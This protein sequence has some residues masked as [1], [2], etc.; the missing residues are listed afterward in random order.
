MNWVRGARLDKYVEENIYKPANLRD[1]CASWRG[2]NGSL[3]GLGI[4]HNDLQHGNVIVQEDEALRLV[5]YDGIFLPQFRGAPSPELGHRNFQHPLRAPEDYDEQVDNFPS[6]VIYLSL[7][8]LSHDPDLWARFYNQEN[9][10]LGKA[11]F[12]DPANSEC[13]KA[14][15]ASP[16]DTVRSLA[17]QLEGFCSIPVGQVPDLEAV[18]GDFSA[19]AR[20]PQANAASSTQ[21]APESSSAAPTTLPTARGVGSEYRMLIQTGLASPPPIYVAPSVP[22]PAPPPGGATAVSSQQT[23]V[24]RKCHLVNPIDLIYCDDERCYAELNLGYNKPCS[25]CSEPVPVRGSYCPECGA[26]LA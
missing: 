11:D 5:D 8:A 22:P 2:A 6:L 25:N 19:V 21:N 23:V 3:R 15:K 20:P 17:E 14:L 9:L 13:F 4:A 24:C 10:L 1:M 18:L 12:S 7:L 26:G 16:N